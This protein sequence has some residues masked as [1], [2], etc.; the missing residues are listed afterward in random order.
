LQ[1]S[2]QDDHHC[3]QALIFP[4]QVMDYSSKIKPYVISFWQFHPFSHNAFG[5][6]WLIYLLE[7]VEFAVYCHLNKI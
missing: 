4:M 1:S 2:R 7:C 5:G 3:R 6:S